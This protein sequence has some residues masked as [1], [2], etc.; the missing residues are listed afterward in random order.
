VGAHTLEP[1]GTGGFAAVTA[2]TFKT[3]STIRNFAF[4]D[5]LGVGTARC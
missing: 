2:G 1:P 3:V 4:T 5:G